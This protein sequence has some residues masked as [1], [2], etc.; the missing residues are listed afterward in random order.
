M[1]LPKPFEGSYKGRSYS[2]W[3]GNFQSPWDG[4]DGRSFE[5]SVMKSL[6]LTQEGWLALDYWDR[7]EWM[8]YTVNE[9]KK[10]L[11]LQIEADRQRAKAEAD[12]KRRK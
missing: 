11:V 12:A 2:E 3:I 10:Q 4:E 6:G 5:L 8:A 9:N 1:T 7:V